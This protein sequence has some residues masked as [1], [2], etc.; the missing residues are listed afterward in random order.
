MADMKDRVKNG[1]DT[2]ADAG[3]RAA[4]NAPDLINRV[5]DNATQVAEK[6]QDK[7][8]Q[9]VDTVQEKAHVVADRVSDTAHQGMRAAEAAGEKV[10]EY[11]QDIADIVKRYPFHA[12]MFGFG[13]GYLLSRAC[14]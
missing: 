1:I 5:A 9:F 13:V 4:D 10:Q 6:V 2:F 14:R 3:K 11:G 12:M 7:A 8:R